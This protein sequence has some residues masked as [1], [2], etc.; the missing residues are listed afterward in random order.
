MCGISVRPSKYGTESQIAYRGRILQKSSK[1]KIILLC[2]HRLAI[3]DTSH[4]GDQ[5]F[6]DDRWVMLCNGEIFNYKQLKQTY[7]DY[8][9]ISHSDCETIIPGC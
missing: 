5:P 4:A 1:L 7:T 3:V 2:F 6:E 8:A 9:Y